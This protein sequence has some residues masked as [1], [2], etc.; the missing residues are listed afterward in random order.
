MVFHPNIPIR[1]LS[2][3]ICGFVVVVIAILV[4]LKIHS[5]S[6]N[7]FAYTLSSF[8]LLMGSS[9][10]GLALTEAFR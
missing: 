10:I 6:K 1:D 4:I 2:Q 3:L 9:S 8:A 5:K 7:K